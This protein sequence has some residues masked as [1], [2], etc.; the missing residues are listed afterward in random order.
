MELHPLAGRHA[1]TSLF[2]IM[3]PSEQE[4]LPRSSLCQAPQQHPQARPWALGSRGHARY[5]AGSVLPPPPPAVCCL[6]LLPGL[7]L[8]EQRLRA[9]LP[10]PPALGNRGPKGSPRRHPR[11]A[12]PGTG[13]EPPAPGGAARPCPPGPPLC[14]HPPD[15]C[16][17]GCERPGGAAGS[18]GCS[19]CCGPSATAS[20]W[21]QRP[22]GAARSAPCWNRLHVPWHHTPPFPLSASGARRHLE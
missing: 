11:R 21:R 9:L 6:R 2:P 17:S 4:S 7:Q 16:R 8:G 12:G 5:T 10:P 3:G 1:L 15:G 18:R 14:P 19:R 22:S 13:R 20:V